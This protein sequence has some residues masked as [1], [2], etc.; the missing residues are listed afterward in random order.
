MSHSFLKSRAQVLVTINILQTPRSM[1]PVEYFQWEDG[2]PWDGIWYCLGLNIG[3][4]VT[5]KH[6]I[7]A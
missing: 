1:K 4:E 3:M 7:T 6:L 5:G 2:R